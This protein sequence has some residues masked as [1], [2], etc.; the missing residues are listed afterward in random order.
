MALELQRIRDEGASLWK[1]LPSAKRWLAGVAVVALLAVVGF[2]GFRGSSESYS[3]LYAGL[4]SEDAG[5]VIE[6]LRAQNV[7]YKLS[8][9]GSVI[10]VPEAKVHELR[11]GLASAGIPRGGGIGF[12]VFDK[13]SFGMTSFVEQMNYRRALSGELA[14]TIMSIDAVERARVHIAMKERSLYKSDDEPPSASVVVHLRNGASLANREVKGIA[15]LVASSVEGLRMDRVTIIDESGRLLW[16]GEEQAIGSDTQRDMERTLARRITDITDRVVG[17]GHAVAV[18]TA[19][20]DSAQSERTEELFDRD[21]A[22][23]RSESKTEERSGMMPGDGAPEGGVSGVRGNSP[24]APPLDGLAPGSDAKKTTEQAGRL[25]VTE[26]RNFEVNRV[27]NRTLSPKVRVARLHVALLVDTTRIRAST[28]STAG[29]DPLARIA[30]LAR[31]AAGLDP[32]RGDRIEAHSIPFAD[33]PSAEGEAAERNLFSKVP[34]PVAIGVGAGALLI[35]AV[36]A[37]AVLRRRKEPKTLVPDTLALP[38]S[39]GQLEAAIDGTPAAPPPAKVE[40]TARER[41]IAAA[42]SDTARAARVLV[43]WLHEQPEPARVETKGEA[44]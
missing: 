8:G 36:A 14:R 39:V 22:A 19:E 9:G 7:A 24:A 38:S 17:P 26:T 41:A 6:Q 29:G 27:F 21:K 28:S 20:L 12:E 33:N 40:I 30:L 34:V 31:E 43:A 5:K 13:Q 44:S 11:I 10:E 42:R 4:G 3:V 25:R 1:T 15:H 35:M 2:L 16:S 18:V 32:N 37:A 23:V